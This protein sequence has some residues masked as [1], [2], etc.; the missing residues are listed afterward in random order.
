MHKGAVR[1][2]GIFFKKGCRSKLYR[3]WVKVHSTSV[4][5]CVSCSLITPDFQII[6]RGRV[7]KRSAVYTQLAE[8]NAK[9]MVCEKPGSGW[10]C[11]L[12]LL[13]R[14]WRTHTDAQARTHAHTHGSGVKRSCKWAVAPP[15]AAVIRS[16][17]NAYLWVKLRNVNEVKMHINLPFFFFDLDKQLLRIWYVS[18]TEIVKR[19]IFLLSACLCVGWTLTEKRLSRRV[20]GP[21]WC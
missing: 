9:A 18:C 14:F 12:A 6:G 13:L 3:T 11:F 4:V 10:W 19:N 16:G 15:S 1:Y 5:G 21:R 7:A 17:A 20:S 2:T 8:Q